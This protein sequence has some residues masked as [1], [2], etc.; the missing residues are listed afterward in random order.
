[1]DKKAIGEQF[2]TNV[3]NAY[4]LSE[5]F[6]Q[7]AM[8]HVYKRIYDEYNSRIAQLGYDIT[9]GRICVEDFQK[10][11][12]EYFDSLN[13]FKK[14]FETVFDYAPEYTDAVNVIFNAAKP[15]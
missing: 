13:H 8:H 12:K 2:V 3:I 14:I 1:M 5:D 15:K 11:M 10:Q 7:D 9:N 6:D 4:I